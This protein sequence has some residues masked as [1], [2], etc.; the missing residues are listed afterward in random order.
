MFWSVSVPEERLNGLYSHVPLMRKYFLASFIL[1]IV[2]TKVGGMCEIVGSCE[3]CSV[4]CSFQ[5]CM[6]AHISSYFGHRDCFTFSEMCFNSDC[7]WRCFFPC[8]AWYRWVSNFSNKVLFGRSLES[9]NKRCLKLFLVCSEVEVGTIEEFLCSK[10]S[11]LEVVHWLEFEFERLKPD[12][13]VWELILLVLVL[14]WC[15][16]CHGEA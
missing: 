13:V 16:W 11:F 12:V 9:V 10:S 4:N 14:D 2:G 8:L 7:R 5:L 6:L 15:I 1:S 3:C